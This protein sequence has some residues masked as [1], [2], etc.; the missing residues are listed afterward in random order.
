M[1]DAARC[2]SEARSRLQ[3]PRQLTFASFLDELERHVNTL[4]SDEVR[5]L[6]NDYMIALQHL[7]AQRFHP[8]ARH[9]RYRKL[10]RSHYS[11]STP[12]ISHLQINYD[13][14]FTMGNQDRDSLILDEYDLNHIEA[15]SFHDLSAHALEEWMPFFELYFPEIDA[16]RLRFD[17][18]MSASFE[19]GNDALGTI[20]SPCRDHTLQMLCIQPG[21]GYDFARGLFMAL[22]E[23]LE[24]CV[25][26]ESLVYTKPLSLDEFEALVYVLPPMLHTLAVQLEIEPS[27]ESPFLELLERTRFDTLTHL[28]LDGLSDTLQTVVHAQVVHARLPDLIHTTTPV[29]YASDGMIGM[30]S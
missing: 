14:V 19:Q 25:M 11:L 22:C 30:T 9:A 26:L 23:R 15:L 1:S 20:L 7:C 16:L 8:H 12:L 4:D 5:R 29:R 24:S 2:F 3:S 27:H 21:Q 17:Y 28:Y 13:E 6:V 18:T 10:L